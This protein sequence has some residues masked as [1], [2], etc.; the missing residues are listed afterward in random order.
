MDQL[1]YD[2][3]CIEDEGATADTTDSNHNKR[4]HGANPTYRHKKKCARLEVYEHETNCECCGEIISSPDTSGMLK[5]TSVLEVELPRLQWHK[6]YPD[7]LPEGQGLLVLSG[8]APCPRG[9]AEA[10]QEDSLGGQA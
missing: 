5:H 7:G 9:A 4:K 2:V 10:D 6:Y 1:S 3:S 8:G